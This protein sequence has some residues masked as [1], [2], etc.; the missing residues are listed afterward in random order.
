MSNYRW[1]TKDEI[2]MI[3]IKGLLKHC[4][5]F[6]QQ[7]FVALTKPATKSLVLGSISD[8]TRTNNQLIAENALL[9]QQLIV[10]NGQFKRPNFTPLDKFRLVLLASLVNQLRNA[11]LILKP[12][13][14]LK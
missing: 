7:Q 3:S 10:L 1:K 6:I 14:I 12:D 4:G 11:L 9:R 2:I 13:T 5:Q 8:L